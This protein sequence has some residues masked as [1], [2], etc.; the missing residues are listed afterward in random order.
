MIRKSVLLENGLGWDK[1]FSPAEDHMLWVNLLDKTMFYN[2]PEVLVLYR[3]HE[4]NTTWT[5]CDKMMDRIALVKS[6]AM[7]KFP[8]HGFLGESF[9]LCLF[10]SIPLL[11]R[12]RKEREDRYYLF[13]KIRI[14]TVKKDM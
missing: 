6:I 5:Q 2:I 10:G 11:R 9:T 12:V 14:F 8:H 3:W 1:D 7:K 4:D 13:G